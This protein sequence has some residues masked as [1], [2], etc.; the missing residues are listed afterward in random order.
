MRTKMPNNLSNK[1]GLECAV[2]P[3][4]LNMAIKNAHRLRISPMIIQKADAVFVCIDGAALEKLTAE[5]YD[6]ELEIFKL[7]MSGCNQTEIARQIGMSQSNVSRKITK[8]KKIL[9]Q[10]E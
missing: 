6:I 4:K 1:N 7:L 9:F 10:S 5:C 3:E 2:S 8:M